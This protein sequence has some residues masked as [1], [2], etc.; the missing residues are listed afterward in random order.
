MSVAAPDPRNAEGPLR[1]VRARSRAAVEEFVECAYRLRTSDP[2]WVPPLR[3]D[4][5]ILLDRL[6]HPFH[7]H[8]RVEYFLARRGNAT[9]GRI[10]AILNHAHNVAHGENVGFF[11]FL[12]A[13]HDREVF[14]ALLKAAE[15]WCRRE[16]L[17]AMRGPCSFSTNEE[18]GLL[19]EGHD[20]SPAVM[21]PHNPP[22]YQGHVE[23]L[24]YA[25]AEDLLC[26]WLTYETYSDRIL[27]MAEMVEKRLE[28]QGVRVQMRTLDVK[29]WTDEVATVKRLYNKAW[30]RNWGFVP[31]TE[32]EM[33]FVAK[34][35]RPV[36]E[37][38]L[39]YFAEVEG[40]PVG[41]TLALPE[42]NM[43]L[44]HMGG[45]LNPWTIAKALAL[46]SS[47]NALRLMM[48]GVLP[49][50]RG[51]GLEVLMYRAMFERA[52]KLGISEGELSW[53]LERNTA[54]NR[55]LEAMGAR[56]YRRYRIYEKP[57]RK[58]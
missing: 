1:I 35:L 30:E 37:P 53:I 25:K 49:E 32:D 42:W 36:V 3:R 55:A 57:L 29:R 23:A 20:I 38:E 16:G 19:V 46:K 27:R 15:T 13:V 50:Y 11:G 47:V 33:D 6:R 51:R 22:W 54:M 12:E 26:W 28:R 34:E 40:E 52:P 56:V 58:G 9:V 44:R 7:R 24:G 10:A 39:V 48:M 45:R 31:M 14:A 8:A 41:F 5:R 43:V 21:T 18:C 2:R 4:V 17:D